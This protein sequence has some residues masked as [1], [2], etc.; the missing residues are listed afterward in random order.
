MIKSKRLTSKILKNFS[1]RS[2]F[3]SSIL[4]TSILVLFVCGIRQSGNLQFLE[5]ATF[6]LMMR[7]EKIQHRRSPEKNRA[8]SR[9]TLVGITESD[10]QTWQQSTFS[11]EL[12]AKLIAELQKHN[13]K[14]IGLDIYRDIPQP[15]GNQALLKQLEADNVIA[16]AHISKD[17][18][19]PP[20]PN[21]PEE[22]IGFNN[23][24]LDDDGTVRRNFVSAKLGDRRLYS[25]GFQ[26]SKKYL[27]LSDTSIDIQP[28]YFQIEQTIFPVLKANSGSYQLSRSDAFG[29]QLL[30]RYQPLDTI[31]RQ[32]SFTDI[33]K[34]NFQPSWIEN[35]VV[36]IGYTAPSK[37]D[38]F[39]TPYGVKKMPG[40]AI[41]TQTVNQILSTVLDRQSLFRF[42]PQWG[43]IIWI[44]IWSSAGAILVWR[45]RHPLVL[46]FGLTVTLIALSVICF[47]LF[48]VGIWIPAVP[49]AIG[50][51]GTTG[52]ILAYKIFYKSMVDELTGLANKEQTIT[53]LQQ[54]IA[55]PKRSAIAVVSIKIERFK[56]INDNLGQ[57]I[58]DRLIILAAKRIQNCIRPQDKLARVQTAQFVLTL[59]TLEEREQVMAIAE[60]IQQ[61]LAQV[62]QIEDR[63]VLIYT[64]LGIAFDDSEPGIQ[65]EELLRNSN[66][67]QDRARVLGKNHYVVFT[68]TMYSESV[69]RWQLENDLREAIANQEFELY[70]QPIID[71]KSDRIA[72]FEALVRWISPTRGFVS[73]GEFIPLAEATDLII[74]LGDWILR[75][76][77]QQMYQ[78]HQQLTPQQKLTISINLS[79]QQFTPEL[80][81]RVKQILAETKLIPECLKLEIT[82]STMINSVEK[83]IAL[84]QE[85]K[86]LGIQLSIDDFGTGYSSLSYLQQFCADTL[87]VDQ[88]FVRQMEL[89]DKDK[90]IVD[91][92]ITLAHKLDMN[93]IAEGI[94]TE[95]HEQILKALNCEYG[96][97][98]L[99]AKPLKSE[100]ATNFLV[101]SLANPLRASTSSRNNCKS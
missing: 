66:I 52:V 40:V 74:P 51:M 42:L 20:P 58:G 81:P 28:N 75:T 87:K 49:S 30:L 84:L 85:L 36:V 63:E 37:K 78:W 60:R 61:Q 99:F 73:P 54:S 15:P 89:S 6:D 95:N 16:I 70:Y 3:S 48:L 32:L 79:S 101:S 31:A 57:Q 88:S 17:N 45:T 92:I 82:E 100:D 55:K 56:T 8:K 50:L 93:A 14:V 11:D 24:L 46:G 53:L 39:S 83:A 68:P 4:I 5:L 9:I 25:L 94:E 23:L 71:L 10:I 91:L 44:W 33:L 77:C 47:G 86:A 80:V 2:I 22:R 98:Y 26:L 34:G 29:A 19:V 62:F 43:E 18:G 12:I 21:V 65:A 97:G 59:L 27:D 35:K 69:A 72:G 1:S 13:P 96:Q 76:A 67:A 64:S 41:H 38:I 7:W 90:A